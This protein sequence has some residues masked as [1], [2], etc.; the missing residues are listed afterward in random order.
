[1]GLLVDLA[2]AFDMDSLMWNPECTYH[3]EVR[4][5]NS[6]CVC[7]GRRSTQSEFVEALQGAVREARA[8]RGR[9]SNFEP[10]YRPRSM[11][12]RLAMTG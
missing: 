1:M 12:N 8:R 10:G 11:K 9:P 3:G 5:S 7:R 4:A 2:D 6:E